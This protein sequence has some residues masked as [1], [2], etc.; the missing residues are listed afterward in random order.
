[1]RRLPALFL[2]GNAKV[3]KDEYVKE[4]CEKK[5]LRRMKVSIEEKEAAFS[6]LSQG[7]LFFGD[8]L[9]DI[10][11]SMTGKRTSGR[12]F[13]SWRKRRKSM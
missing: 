10:V 12:N 5:K 9:L 1:V 13:C 8:V 11:T 3:L 4:I 6:L 2:V 7:D